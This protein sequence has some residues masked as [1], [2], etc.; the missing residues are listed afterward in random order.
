MFV[1]GFINFQICNN[2]EA[3]TKTIGNFKHQRGHY[4]T[5]FVF[6]IITNILGQSIP[7]RGQLTTN[8]DNCICPCC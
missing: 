6:K 3:S 5:C 8:A 2:V 7:V 1:H 4:A